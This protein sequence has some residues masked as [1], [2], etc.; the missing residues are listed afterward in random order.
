MLDRKY[1]L[2]LLILAALTLRAG[3]LAVAIP[4]GVLLLLGWLGLTLFE[5]VA[6]FIAVNGLCSHLGM[7]F[8]CVHNGI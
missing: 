5:A 8:K 7:R 4:I 6:N 3:L 1:L 2:A